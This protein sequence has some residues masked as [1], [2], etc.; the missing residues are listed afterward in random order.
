MTA[1]APSALLPATRRGQPGQHLAG[2]CGDFTEMPIP[3]DSAGLA[4]R[5][6]L[7][8]LAEAE[9]DRVSAAQA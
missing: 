8:A 1:S 9:L 4:M 5:R 7:K 2:R 6:H 3:T